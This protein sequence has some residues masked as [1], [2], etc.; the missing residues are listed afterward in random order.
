[1][2][3]VR[4]K[5]KFQELEF[6]S[7]N[8]M[9]SDMPVAGEDL[10]LANPMLVFGAQNGLY[11]PGPKIIGPNEPE[12]EFFAGYRLKEVALSENI[13]SPGTSKELREYKAAGMA[14]EQI[15]R[16][17]MSGAG[18]LF[19][20]KATIAFNW[21]SKNLPPVPKAPLSLDP[22]ILPAGSLLLCKSSKNAEG[23]LS[24]Q[25]F[26]LTPDE[27]EAEN[28]QRKCGVVPWNGEV[29][30][31]SDL[32]FSVLHN[33]DLQM[34]M[35]RWPEKSKAVHMEDINTF[36]SLRQEPKPQL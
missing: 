2:K 20:Q 29:L 11:Y 12:Y 22:R 10:V 26:S 19:S 23:K 15:I 35:L 3:I 31:S 8:F 5:G 18:G 13:Y 4:P 17:A 30:V 36:F 21:A 34:L 32:G 27:Q 9:T 1:M 25:W 14:L 16:D 6:L 33:T 28:L 7:R 24:D